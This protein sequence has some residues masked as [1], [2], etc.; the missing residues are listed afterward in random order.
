MERWG[1]EMLK[2]FTDKAL[3]EAAQGRPVLKLTLTLAKGKL[4]RASTAINIC[5][6]ALEKSGRYKVF[7]EEVYTGGKHSIYIIKSDAWLP[8]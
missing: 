5:W 4:P 7:G 3:K 2:T 6:R 1:S 8:K